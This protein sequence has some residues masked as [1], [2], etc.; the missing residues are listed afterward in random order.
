MPVLYTA[1]RSPSTF[2]FV[3]VS[4]IH[5]AVNTRIVVVYRPPPSRKARA[6][7]STFLHEFA[8]LL[9]CLAVANGR[10]VILGDFNIH[11]DVQDNPE[12]TKFR[13]L[14][15]AHNLRQMVTFPTHV[16]GHTIDHVITR[17][18]ETVIQSISSSEWITDHVSIH[19]V[20]DFQ[21]PLKKG[22]NCSTA[23]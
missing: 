23:R 1:A 7:F 10:L 15:D 21:K 17:S 2:Q 9:A 6:P 19:N 12:T 4:I 22:P 16:S 14:L 13:D 5:N 3:E 8:D 18:S 20:L 11:W